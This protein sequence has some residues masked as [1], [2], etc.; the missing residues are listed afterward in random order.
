MPPRKPL[1][2]PEY[3]GPPARYT[4]G[5]NKPVD[6]L[7]VH[8]TVSPC[9]PGG[10]YDIA[11]YFRSPGAKGSA[12]YVTD[13]AGAVQAAWDRVICWHAPPNPRSLGFEMCD[14]PG[15]VPNE[16]PGSARWKML[17]RSWRWAR[18]KQRAMI[19][20]TA[21]LVAEAC[22][23][24][25]VPPV[26]LGPKALRAGRRGITTHANVSKAWGQ[27]THWDPGWWPR[28]RFIRLVRRHVRTIQESK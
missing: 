15:P 22:V 12:H 24:H 23:V 18:P 25:Q 16:R 17:R 14:I 28:R 1:L 26:F 21:R 11:R 10:R 27:S 3:V 4:P 5:D 8:S 6:R 2:S 13:P 20:I 7:V 9:V 19:R